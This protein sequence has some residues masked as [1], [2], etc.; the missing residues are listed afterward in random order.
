MGRERERRMIT[1]EGRRKEEKKRECPDIRTAPRREIFGFFFNEIIV[2]YGSR[3]CYSIPGRC[4]YTIACKCT[5][6][7][8]RGLLFQGFPHPSVFL[9]EHKIEKKLKKQN[10]KKKTKKKS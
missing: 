5:Y 3:L 1:S 9:R 6:I 10:E 4:Y 8:A 2:L 7:H